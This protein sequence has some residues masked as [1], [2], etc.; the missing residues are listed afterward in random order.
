MRISVSASVSGSISCL[1]ACAAST[2]LVVRRIASLLPSTSLDSVRTSSPN[3]DSS[4]SC[5]S[6]VFAAASRTVADTGTTLTR[7]P[8]AARRALLRSATIRQRGTM[9]ILVSTTVTTGHS[10]VTCLSSSSSELHSSPVASEIMRTASA[11]AS[12]AKVD[13]PRSGPVL[14]IAGVSTSTRPAASSSRGRPTSA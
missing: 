9:S 11:L 3:P 5:L 7:R 8:A 6:P 2:A 12:A 13:A 1:V 14:L 10:E 4:F